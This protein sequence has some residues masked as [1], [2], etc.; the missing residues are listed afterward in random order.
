MKVL[1]LSI[2]EKEYNGVKY[3]VLILLTDDKENPKKEIGTIKDK[4]VNC[5][6]KPPFRGN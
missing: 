3:N 4:R 5:Y 1:G 2:E 6:T